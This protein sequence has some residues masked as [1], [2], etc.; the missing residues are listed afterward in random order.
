M[1]HVYATL[2]YVSILHST[3]SSEE[4]ELY[5]LGLEHPS[6]CKAVNK[7]KDAKERQKCYCVH[8]DTGVIYTHMCM[9]TF[10]SPS[11]GQKRYGNWTTFFGT[12]DT[13]DSETATVSH[14]PSV[15]KINSND[16]NVIGSDASTC[17]EV[18][19]KTTNLYN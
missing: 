1:I 4:G 9:L 10:G 6:T 13:A 2:S 19:N 17:Q 16:T 12:D 18:I 8:V 5:V 11:N 15:H 14:A 7:S 3:E